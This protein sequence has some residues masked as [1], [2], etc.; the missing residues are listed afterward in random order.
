MLIPAKTDTERFHRYIWDA[1]KDPQG[2]RPNVEVRFLKGR[3]TFVGAEEGSTYP[4]MVV[5]FRKG[6]QDQH[7]LSEFF[8]K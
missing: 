1:D 5:I 3:I 4:S 7:R 8:S 6:K 2:P